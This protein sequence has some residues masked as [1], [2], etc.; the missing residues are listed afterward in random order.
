MTAMTRLAI[1]LMVG[2]S[3][4]V[5]GCSSDP[6]TFVSY[7]QKKGAASGTYDATKDAKPTDAL[8]LNYAN[9]VEEIFR[10]RSTGA[11]YTREASDTALAG[12]SAFAGAAE[13]LSI[14]ASALSGMGLAGVAILD[15]RKI[16]DARGRSTAYFEAAQRIHGAIKDFRAYN[17]NAVSDEGLSPNGWTLANVVQANIDI[18]AMILNGNLPPPAILT[19]A[20]E[21]MSAE[22]AYVV[23]AP[24][25]IPPNNI[26]AA[27][28]VA[29]PSL[30]QA[31][32]EAR[33]AA[34]RA[35]EPAPPK[36]SV[37]VAPPPP[38]PEIEDGLPTVPQMRAKITALVEDKHF[39]A[40]APQFK[41]ILRNAGLDPSAIAGRSSATKVL[42]AY[43]DKAAKRRQINDA[44][45]NFP[46][47]PPLLPPL[48]PL[49][50]PTP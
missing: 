19:Q 33:L 23:N 22:G 8:A 24:A 37:T 50:S 40:D 28:L 1:S 44:V 36:I 46:P 31:T 5:A 39:D 9:G 43:K 48:A 20:S 49:P 35:P 21:P 7:A 2:W 12:L 25:K 45:D 15:L 34:W 26:P 10:A 3:G 42:E 47:A 6:A 18:V 27:P 13:T 29:G 30:A 38:P 4:F 11:R 14:S 16:F 41:A 32:R 17:L